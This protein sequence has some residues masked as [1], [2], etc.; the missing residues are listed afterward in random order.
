[1]PALSLDIEVTDVTRSM[2]RA[3]TS[4]SPSEAKSRIAG[5]TTLFKVKKFPRRLKAYVPMSGVSIVYFDPNGSVLIW[6]GESD[7]VERGKWFLRG[8]RND[9]CLAFPQGGALALCTNF[10]QATSFVK[11][12]TRGNPFKLKGGAPVP[13]KLGHMGVSLE[14]TARK[15]P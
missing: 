15:F 13:F 10:R 4:A 8:Q 6:S 5:Y 9:I 2:M 7:K 1:M 14:R 11:E 3:H 12:T